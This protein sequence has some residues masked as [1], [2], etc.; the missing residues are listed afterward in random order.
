MND[1]HWHELAD[2]KCMDPECSYVNEQAWDSEPTDEEFPEEDGI[3][4]SNTKRCRCG[5]VHPV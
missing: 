1:D 2:G 4:Y 3:V 5:Q